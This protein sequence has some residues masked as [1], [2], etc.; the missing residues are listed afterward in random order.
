MTDAETRQKF[1]RALS[2]SITWF[3]LALAPIIVIIAAAGGDG[4]I[5]AAAILVESVGDVYDGKIARR[6]GVATA[7]LRRFDSRVDT[8]FYV[9]VAIALWLAHRQILIDHALLFGAFMLFQIAGMV[10]DLRKF[11][12]DTSYHTWTGR[13]LGLT[14]FIATTYIFATGSA[15]P[16]LDIALIAGIISNIDALVITAILPEWRHD[17]HTVFQALQIRR[18]LLSD[19]EWVSAHGP[20]NPR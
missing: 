3:R 6:F 14:L 8:I 20:T 19:P 9:G 13:A 17:V 4:R 10:V 18:S 12:R 15:G 11:G 1:G 7:R 5:I 16:W 2:L